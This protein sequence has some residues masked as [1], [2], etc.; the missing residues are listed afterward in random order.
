MQLQ[1]IERALFTLLFSIFFLTGIHAKPGFIENIGQITDQY[2]TPRPDIIAKYPARKGLTIFL[3]NSGIHYQFVTESEMYRMD[4]K[5]IGAN[6][7]A[8]ISKQKPGTFK[9]QYQLADVKGVASSFGKLTYHDVYPGIDWAFYF[10]EHGDLEHDFIIKPGGSVSDIRLEY[11]GSD[12]LKIDRK[13]DLIA[14]TRFGQI[15]EPKPYSYEQGTGRTIASSYKLEGNTLTFKTNPY[16]GTLVIDPIISWSTYIGGSEFDEIRDV[17]TG[18]DGV[19]YA[20]G[21]TNS[22]TNIATIGAHLT[23]FQGGNNS[24]G[25]DAFISKFSPFGQCLWSTYFGGSNVD[26]G[27]ALAI[28]TTG[29]LYMAGRTNSSTGISTPGSYQEVKAGTNAGYDV[30][31]VK[32]DTAGLPVWGTYYGGSSADGLESV[33]LTIDRY[34]NLYLAGNTQSAN[35]IATTNAFQASRPGNQDGFI[36]KFNTA[37]NLSWATYFGTSTNDWINAI[38]TDTTGNI[39]VVGQSQGTTGLSTTGAYKEIGLGLTDGFI[40]KFDSAGARLWSSYFGGPDNDR[41]FAVCTD[42]TNAIYISGITNSTSDI[43]TSGAHQSIIGS[44]TDGLIAKFD[45]G[46]G[47]LWSTY[48]GGTD[49]DLVQYL[50]FSKGKLYATGSTLSPNNITTP[51]AIVPVYN[52]SFSEGFL[53]T[54]SAGGQRQWATYFGGDVTEE[55]RAIAIG[56]A[57]QLY[58]GGKTASISGLASMGSHQSTFGGLQDG[59]LIAINMCNVPGTPVAISGQQTVCENSQQQYSITPVAGASSYTW[60]LPAGS[61]W[62]GSS[63]TE[64]IM[65]TIGAANGDIKVV[66]NNSCGNSDTIALSITVNP[67]PLPVISR[68]GNI[69]SVSQT[70]NSYQWLLDGST[71]PGATNPTHVAV[72]NGTYTLEVTGSNGCLGI[73]NEILIDNGTSINPGF[74]EL[75]IKIFPNPFFANLNIV[76]PVP[77]NIKIVDLTG[78]TLKSMQLSIGAAQVDLSHLPAGVYLLEAY[79]SANEKLGSCSVV[80]TT[81]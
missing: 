44:A 64:N 4:V 35:Q 5:L 37:G 52:N 15:K 6:A 54:F 31:L 11:L 14:T 17:K 69:L 68:S 66:A 53:A 73:S 48:F 7:N 79:T 78:K 8:R 77:L 60:I 16:K 72:A 32:F 20:V 45:Q 36:V 50:L 47:L 59:M 13:G 29:F 71:I 22:T 65:V 51:D 12:G 26:L 81:P 57:D 63:N 76:V 70:F 62:S 46:G 38:T 74:A 67:A 33:A 49:N 75:G 21:S 2:Y 3:S 43:S 61:G 23:T 41:L 58:I 55:P 40:A 9:E 24:I 42:S 25:S 34:N 80:K 27:L 56:N 1:C 18:K 28:D 10:N 30:Y 19:V 39:I